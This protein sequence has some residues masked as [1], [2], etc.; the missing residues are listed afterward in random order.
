[1]QVS[2]YNLAIG[3]KQRRYPYEAC[4]QSALAV[5]DEFCIA[6]DPR[7][8]DPS[9]FTSVD[10]R[11][12]PVRMCIDFTEW[13]FVNIALTK[14]RHECSGDWCL[15]LEM[16]EV[17]HEKDTDNIKA[18]IARANEE[19]LESIHTR[20]ISMEQNYVSYEHFGKHPS[21]EKLTV[22]QPYIYHK[23][24]DYMIGYIDSPYWGGKC[25]GSYAFD[26]FSYY[27]ERTHKWFNGKDS[28]FT[29][30]GYDCPAEIKTPSAEIEYKVAHYTHVWHYTGYNWSRKIRQEQQRKT[31][32]DRTFGRSSDLDIPELVTRLQEDIIMIPAEAHVHLEQLKQQGFVKV[33]LEHPV[34][35]RAWIE[36]MYLDC[37]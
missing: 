37:Q 16:D 34:Y 20:Y 25:I 23:T 8:D 31:W 35:V 5:A 26:D 30:E 33:H 17:L 32:Q 36:G 10:D 3:V 29:E 9:I 21:R 18:A 14:A 11:V 4:I 24:S 7:F 22:N 15:Y 2:A 13:D 12:R 19:H 28:H 1:M 27:D 6:Y